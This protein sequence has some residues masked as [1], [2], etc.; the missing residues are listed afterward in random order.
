M[1]DHAINRLCETAV[2]EDDVDLCNPSP[3][4][5]RK[6]SAAI[7]ILKIREGVMIGAG[8]KNS[9]AISRWGA[10]RKLAQVPLFHCFRPAAIPACCRRSGVLSASRAAI[11]R[12]WIW[13]SISTGYIIR[14]SMAMA[15][16]ISYF[17]MLNLGLCSPSSSRIACTPADKR[18][19]CPIWLRR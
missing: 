14:L 2:I 7:A 16:S 17:A 3:R 4:R 18:S 11:S 8:A 10:A 9:S 1:L 12:R 15:I 13:T 6:T 19:P 5:Y